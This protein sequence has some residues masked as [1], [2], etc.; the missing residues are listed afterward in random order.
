MNIRSVKPVI[1]NQ[2]K[3]SACKVMIEPSLLLF[4]DSEEGYRMRLLFVQPGGNCSLQSI[5]IVSAGTIGTF[6]Q[7]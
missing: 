4:I 6:L 3:E 7:L 5:C 1:I 2:T